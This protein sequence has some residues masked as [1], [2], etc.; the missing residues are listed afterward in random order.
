MRKHGEEDVNDQIRKEFGRFGYVQNKSL[1]K[2]SVYPTL[3]GVACDNCMAILTYVPRYLEGHEYRMYN[4]YDVHFYASFALIDLWPKLQVQLCTS[5][6]SYSMIIAS[7]G[8]CPLMFALAYFA[9][10]LKLRF[11]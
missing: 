4:T 8:V 7:L 10:V 3:P 6:P 9:V 1:F 11:R 2:Q 5:Q